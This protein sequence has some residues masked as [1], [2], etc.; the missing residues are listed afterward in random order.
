MRQAARRRRGLGYK[1]AAVLE[2]R[3]TEVKRSSFSA[4]VGLAQDQWLDPANDDDLFELYVLVKVLVELEEGLGFDVVRH[5]GLIRKDRDAVAEVEDRDGRRIVVYADQGMQALVK[6]SEYVAVLREY[7]E[8]RD[9]SHR[10][11]D[12]VLRL[13]DGA[14]DRIILLE[15]KRS[16]DT[17]YLR[18][19]LYKV[20]GYL[21]DFKELWAGHPGKPKA[22]LIVPGK[23]RPLVK[24]T[25]LDAAIAG[26]EESEWLRELIRAGLVLN[27]KDIAPASAGPQSPEPQAASDVQGPPSLGE[28]S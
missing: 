12:L 25:D 9:A 19:G 6:D 23:V 10:R 27:G 15:M 8:F 11:P 5:Y 16:D 7:E 2:S 3:L 22:I 1:H 4:L 17:R 26:S 24:M 14:I 21:R 18:N 20:L 28:L 13:R